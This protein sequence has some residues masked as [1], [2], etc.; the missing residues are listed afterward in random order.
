MVDGMRNDE[1]YL[2]DKRYAARYCNVSIGTIDRWIA[3]GYGPRFIK[4]GNLV[5]YRPEDLAAFV[6][7]NA[8]GG[9]LPVGANLGIRA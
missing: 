2:K 6:E 8:R 3:S 1:P 4:M 7:A 9:L 5:R